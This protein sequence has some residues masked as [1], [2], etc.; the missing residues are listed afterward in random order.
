[1]PRFV[2]LSRFVLLAFVSVL[3]MLMGPS[4]RAEP[5]DP[6][7]VPPELKPWVP[8]VLDGQD[9]A[10]CPV[11]RQGSPVRCAWPARVDLVLDEKSGRFTQ[12]WH[13]DAP[14]WVPLPGDAK[15]WPLDVKNGAQAV[16][17][18]ARGG[19]P[20]V[21]LERGDH[22]LTGLFAWDTMPESL[23][24]PKETGLLSLTM[25]G[26]QVASP[27]RDGQGIV[28][29]QKAA[30][31]EEGDAI[32][33]VVH[34]K[35][36]DDIPLRLTTRIEVHAS[37][38]NREEL[39]GKALPDG[40]VPLS[41]DSPIPARV[42]P[43]GHVRVQLRPG[44]FTIELVARGEN[45]V[46]KLARPKPNGPWR[47]GDE[48][49][50]FEAKNDYRV[51]TVEG[52]PSIDPA[53]TTLPDTW[54]RLPAYPMKLT[55]T[56]T[57]TERRRGDA[58]PPQNQLALQRKLWLDFDGRGFTASDT[59]TGTLSRDS[60]LTMAEPTLL[61]RVAIGGKDQFITKLDGLGSGVE[62][63]QGQLFVAA[64]SRIATSPRDVPA[65][66]WAHDFH[67]VHAWLNL[68]PGYRLFHASG[69]DDVSGTWVRHWSLLELFLALVLSVAIG[70]LYGLRWG[71]VALML[72]GLSFPEY[73]APKWVWFPPLVCEALFRVMP[74]TPGALK[75]KK[76]FEWARGFALAIVAV[77]AVPFLVQHVREGACP[78][79]GDPMTLAEEEREVEQSHDNKEGGTG[80]RAKGEEGSMGN[81]QF[82]T[83]P[84][85]PPAV[86][87]GAGG[88][89]ADEPMQAQTGE[90]EK[91]GK[92]GENKPQGAK[93][94]P[95]SDSAS[96]LRSWPSKPKVR[97]GYLQSNAAEYDP[98]AIV[99]T[100][101]GLPRW[102][103]T[104]LEL[105]W[106]GP[107]AASQRLHLYLL[108]PAENFALALLRALLL[109]VVFLR[110]FP[111][112]GKYFPKGW[113]PPPAKPD[114]GATPG[115]RGAGGG[116]V[117]VASAMAMAL[118]LTLMPNVA[119]AEAPSS[120]MLEE[121]QKKL[122]QKPSC[123]PDCTSSGRMQIETRGD[124]LRARIEVESAATA[125]FALPGS[126]GQFSPR[127]V[128]VDGQPA[129][130][131]ARGDDGVLYVLVGPG[132]HQVIV[133]GSLPE[134]ESM[135][136]SLPQKPHRVDVTVEGWT[137]E[138]IH[139]DGLADDNLQ[140]TRKR[141]QGAGATLQP[142]QLPPFVRVERTLRVGLNW[143]VETRVVRVSP[144]GSAVV[145]EVPLLPGE[146]VT[147]A[148]VRVVAG[149]ALV[150]MGAQ[151][152]EVAWY[153]V[154]EQR[155]P[156]KLVAPKGTAWTEVWRLD[157]GP[158]WHAKYGGIPFVH[159]QPQDGVR[160]P[161][162]RP[163]PGEEATVELTR[164][165]GV[166][167]QT[168]TIDEETLEVRPGIRTTD[169]KLTLSVRSSR[170][171][172][173]TVTLPEGATLESLVLNG[174]TQAIR[175]DARKVTFPVVP[176]AQTVVLAW[177]EET[178]LSPFFAVSPVDIGA[179]S[180]NANVTIEVPGGRWLLFAGGPRLGP[181][182]LFWSL[183]AVLLVVAVILGR[184]DKTPLK[185]WHWLLLAVG[186]SQVHIVLAAFFVAWLLALGYRE[187][188]E[189]KTLAPAAFNL[190][191]LGL[192]ALTAVAIGVLFASIY[193]GL[194]GD[195]EMQVRGNGSSLEHLRWFQ[196]R[197]EGV[198]PVPWM[199]SMPILVY[200]ALMLG[201][202]L[203]TALAIVRWLKWGWGAFTTGGG[204]KSSPK[205]TFAPAQGPQQA[206]QQAWSQQQQ[207]AWAAQQA[208]RAQAEAQAQA[209]AAQGPTA[210]A[211]P[212][213]P[214]S[215]SLAA[216]EAPSSPS[217][218]ADPSE[219]S[220]PEPDAKE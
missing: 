36:S 181:A 70:R 196:D 80:T 216:T 46:S 40:F 106:S 47:E 64:D 143:Q 31:N 45:A 132:K 190:R 158:I 218:G 25:R 27:N 72:Y 12:R 61:G 162:W 96:D 187:K 173:H 86:V 160:F 180:V 214:A 204:W 208:Q 199:L 90:L 176:G 15:R 135:Q 99:Q 66:S 182:V 82:A 192:V 32:E 30:K 150:N 215:P 122:V 38:K 6:K 49:W 156:V 206:A 102:K 55:D 98:A 167:G 81:P 121:L 91:A 18:L 164:P 174:A 133:E 149:K 8:W 78:A 17:V 24:V 170:G 62:I 50:V 201:W 166:P 128:T 22:V 138:G 77:V 131:L 148:D 189:G 37:G 134:R 43:D 140:F 20:Q 74:S 212:A 67:Q 1:M 169:V 145:L 97:P 26:A 114:A 141:T 33:I 139:E 177:R 89:P 165:E 159:T 155:S 152:T 153:S 115:G 11:T 75:I 157:I 112:T 83:S 58:D 123:S 130:A 184:N 5:L 175:Q 71:V 146:N 93:A 125:P 92:G 73:G 7:V 44:V 57:L 28:W 60:R 142:G 127:E 95:K 41:L 144:P 85:A 35:V 207:Q 100:G 211:S 54:K 129:K 68:P 195:P 219:P 19:V 59:L 42:E 136:L 103:W 48:V 137:V 183:L 109:V 220:P 171:A 197:S 87:A 147:T 84:A 119:R 113:G 65:V 185:T 76:V 10:L 179:P 198:L 210:V 117:A 56:F 2:R 13:L 88:K 108:S 213:S 3:V 163:W 111:F 29:L 209:H 34:R 205:V 107:V 16:S 203:W 110:L 161:E 101:P 21:R 105:K 116:V 193:K 188:S 51:V 202:A 178:G 9:E 200:R 94:E 118:V 63:R 126:I 154:L 39:L 168:L 151:A 23:K 69:V 4:A 194:L 120:S 53:Q 104:S 79:L 191:Q 217:A 124:V 186:L 14:T 172:E 52:V